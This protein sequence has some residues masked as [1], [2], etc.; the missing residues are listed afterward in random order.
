MK[1]RLDWNEW[2]Q[3]PLDKKKTFWEANGV[4]Y[5]KTMVQGMNGELEESAQY[6]PTI[7]E[8]IQFLGDDLERIDFNKLKGADYVIIQLKTSPQVVSAND[9]VGALWTAILFKLAI[10][11]L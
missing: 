4:D 6:V 9:F 1:Y 2:K 8:M 3:V 11:N 10:E 7:I 5:E